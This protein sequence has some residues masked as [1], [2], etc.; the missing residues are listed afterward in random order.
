MNADNFVA[1]GFVGWLL[2]DLIQ[3]AYDLND[4]NNESLRLALVAIGVAASA[5][6]AGA[7]A[8]ALAPAKLAPETWR[9]PH[10]TAAPWSAWC[11]FAFFSAC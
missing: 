1:A 2:L 9:R 11:R 8:Q 5:M 4:A 10:W 6:W 7:I 3:G